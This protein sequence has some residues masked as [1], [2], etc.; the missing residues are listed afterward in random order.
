MGW[1]GYAIGTAV[2]LAAADFFIKV[3]AGK[4]SNSL[5]LL[6]YGS[7]TFSLGLGWVLLDKLQGV[8]IHAQAP[9]VLAATGV[10]V[11]FSVVT[12]GLYITFGAGAPITLASPLVRLGGLLIVS[13]AGFLLLHEPLTWRYAVGMVLAVS[14]LYL[15]I[16]R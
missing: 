1:I 8:S 2:A 10:G 15:I 5:A 6:L 9:G 7:C 11:A 13:L 16:T 3:A 14:G 4:L 12:V